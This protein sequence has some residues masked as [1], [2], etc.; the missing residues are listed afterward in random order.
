MQIFSLPLALDLGLLLWW[1]HQIPSLY[2]HSGFWL[3][4]T[5]SWLLHSAGKI[6]VISACFVKSACGELNV[7]YL[8]F[9]HSIRGSIHS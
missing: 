7:K 4:I 9:I 8:G 2:L 3:S 5:F 1:F 6:K